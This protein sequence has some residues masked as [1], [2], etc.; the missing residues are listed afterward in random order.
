MKV[1]NDST[2]QSGWFLWVRISVEFLRRDGENKITVISF[3]LGRWRRALCLLFNGRPRQRIR[4]DSS[5]N[6]L[7]HP[8]HRSTIRFAE[9]QRWWWVNEILL[10]KI[11]H[12]QVNHPNPTKVSWRELLAWNEKIISAALRTDVFNVHPF[13]P[14]NSEEWK[15]ILTKLKNDMSVN[16]NN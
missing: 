10:K 4:D 12:D 9:G 3:F 7:V 8:R 16:H 14:D 6:L 1:S 2:I 5:L 13:W 15:A 11:R